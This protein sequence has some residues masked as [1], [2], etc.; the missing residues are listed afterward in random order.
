MPDIPNNYDPKASDVS[1]IRSS[2]RPRWDVPLRANP[3]PV[4]GRKIVPPEPQEIFD[5]I[6]PHECRLADFGGCD[7]P[8]ALMARGEQPEPVWPTPT[9]QQPPK[10]KI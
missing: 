2:D 3:R 5:P 10:K 4:F 8:C 1:R 7:G 6:C 9:N